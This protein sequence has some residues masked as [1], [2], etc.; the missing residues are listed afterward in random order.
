MNSQ[1]II[2]RAFRISGWLS[3]KEALYL[4]NIHANIKTNT[5]LEIGSFL[6]RSTV[7]SGSALKPHKG[8]LFA[9]DPHRKVICN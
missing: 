3:R 8:K 4:Y 2:K 5:A 7:I 9:I 1:E 6:G